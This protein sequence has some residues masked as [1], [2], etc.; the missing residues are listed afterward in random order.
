MAAGEVRE[1]RA[2]SVERRHSFSLIMTD[3][4]CLGPL[5]L[6]VSQA[7]PLK[8]SI[9]NSKFFLMINSED[10]INL[11]LWIDYGSP[12]TLKPTLDVLY[13]N[14]MMTFAQRGHPATGL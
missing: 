2:R 3:K 5:S 4:K 1:V 11:N 10:K 6:P 8:I 9:E 7:F 13:Q 12:R 14:I